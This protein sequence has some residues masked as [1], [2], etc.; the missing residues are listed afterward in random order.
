MTDKN[1]EERNTPST[2]TALNMAFDGHQYE[3]QAVYSFVVEGQKVSRNLHVSMRWRGPETW[4][5]DSTSGWRCFWWLSPSIQLML[6]Y[7]T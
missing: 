2:S 1:V 4:Y 3:E 7:H 5:L 6:L